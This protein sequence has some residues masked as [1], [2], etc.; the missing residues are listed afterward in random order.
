MPAGRPPPAGKEV[1]SAAAPAPTGA[2][3]PAA[4]PAG[5]ARP[6]R[7]A[8]LPESPCRCV[9]RGRL[10]V[11]RALLPQVVLP[12]QGGRLYQLGR[13]CQWRLE[14]HCR[15]GSQCRLG[16]WCRLGR[17][18]QWRLG[19]RLH[20]KVEAVGLQ[21]NAPGRNVSAPDSQEGWTASREVGTRQHRG[22]QMGPDARGTEQHT[23]P[24]ARKPA[25]A[26]LLCPRRCLTPAAAHLKRK[27][28]PPYS[29]SPPHQTTPH[30][31]S[32]P[33]A[34]YLRR[35]LLLLH[36]LL[37]SGQLLQACALQTLI[38]GHAHSYGLL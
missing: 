10:L 3:A 7:R 5:D 24:G 18:G 6:L 4:T 30:H 35:S 9:M 25:C 34:L 31:T 16:R 21:R 13:P 23:R 36:L 17:P 38:H 28:A 8:G 1:P 29:G 27:H 37:F 20:A 26:C 22:A 11:V 32:G 15:L 2:A 14:H 12:G 19:R 33:R